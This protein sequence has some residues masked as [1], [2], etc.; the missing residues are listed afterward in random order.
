MI[1]AENIC[2]KYY[3]DYILKNINF[4]VK[5]GEIFGIIG[6]TGSGKSTLVNILSGLVKP[7]EGTAFID[8][9]N[10]F[11]K[12]ESG[13]LLSKKIST[14]FQHP[15]KQLFNKCIYDD[16]AFSMRNQNIPED[17]IK[18]NIAEV[19]E[20]L[21]MS[22][23][24]LNSSPFC[25]SG[26]E[27]RKCAL[28]CALVTKPKILILDEPTSGLDAY[29]ANKFLNYIKKY[30]NKEKSTIIFASNSVGN[31]A[32]LCD[33]ILILDN[34]EEKILDKPENIFKKCKELG[35]SAPNIWQ[36]ISI[37]NSKGYNIPEKTSTISELQENIWD[38]IK[39]KE[40]KNKKCKI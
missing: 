26:G 7:D 40:L 36:I 10:I 29:T 23:D 8:G 17:I 12:K 20:F 19:S 37:I 13:N 1:H 30:H 4:S 33:K 5:S 21:N 11:N 14:V 22:D 38:L 34:G 3:K 32:Y 24:I 16:I 9:K 27:K 25:I 28:A 15:E 2:F 35:F 6:K 18:K 31:F 39:R